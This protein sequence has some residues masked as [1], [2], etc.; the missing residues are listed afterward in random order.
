MLAT[1]WAPRAF[2]GR[3][4]HR[5]RDCDDPFGPDTIIVNSAARQLTLVLE[6]DKAIRYGCAMGRDGFRWAGL[7]GVGR[8][9]MW[10]RWTPPKETVELYRRAPIGTRVVV[11][12]EGV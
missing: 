1:R 8:K 10:P 2:R 12:A 4:S 9:V 6:G 5:E 11:L 7:A 3:R